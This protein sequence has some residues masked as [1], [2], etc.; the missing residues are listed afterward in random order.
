MRMLSGNFTGQSHACMS[1]KPTP[2]RQAAINDLWRFHALFQ[3][4]PI[5]KLFS[6]STWP[7]SPIQR[8]YWRQLY[9]FL[10]SK[11][12]SVL[13]PAVVPADPH[14]V[15]RTFSHSPQHISSLKEHHQTLPS[16]LSCATSHCPQTERGFGRLQ[17]CH[18]PSNKP[19]WLANYRLPL[20]L[21]LVTT[22]VMIVCLLTVCRSFLYTLMTLP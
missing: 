18:Q 13:G 4:S 12:V 10:T 20:S 3:S 17:T 21:T 8:R 16:P 2:N 15:S 11:F 1:V 5:T 6:A 14:A 19:M 9:T 22:D 7:P